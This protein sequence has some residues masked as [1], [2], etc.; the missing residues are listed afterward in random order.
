[1]WSRKYTPH[2][3]K[4]TFT[5]PLVAFAIGIFLCFNVGI[6][7]RAIGQYIHKGR[8]LETA[9]MLDIDL[10]DVSQYPPSLYT[11]YLERQ[12]YEAGI[13]RKDKKIDI[14]TD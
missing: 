13:E 1:M 12:K 4:T 14:V 10:D 9:T 6:K 5:W 7:K 2:L 3:H 8:R 11:E